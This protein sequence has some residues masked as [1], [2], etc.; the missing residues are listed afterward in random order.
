MLALVK[1]VKCKAFG[2]NVDTGSFRTADPYGDLARIVPYGV[3]S[4]VKT[5]IAPGGKKEEADLAR[6][7]KM[8]KDANFH[9]FVAAEYE[10]SEDPKV[11][12]PRHVRNCGSSLDEDRSH[13]T[14]RSHRA[15]S[16]APAPPAP[17]REQ[18]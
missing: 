3:V 17:D 2:V 10:A 11:A 9:G 14:H 12:V 1:P 18:P 8:L 7:I 5:E 6:L 15:F 4:Q 13:R 16:P